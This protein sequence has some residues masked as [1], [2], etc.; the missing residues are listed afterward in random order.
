MPVITTINKRV[1]L[2]YINSTKFKSIGIILDLQ[3]LGY[4]I[5][6]KITIHF[7]PPARLLVIFKDIKDI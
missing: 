2:K 7:S 4:P 1:D 6:N 3:Y 5:S